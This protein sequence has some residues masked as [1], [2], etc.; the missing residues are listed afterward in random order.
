MAGFM[1]RFLICNVFISGM[2]GILLAA[3]QIFKNILSGRMQYNLWF[4]LLGLLAVPFMPFRFIGFP[5]IFSWLD[6]LGYS[7]AFNAG[8]ATGNIAGTTPTGNTDWINDFTL[9]VNSKT[10]S[11]IGY[12]LLAIW[13]AGILA[14]ILLVIKS[15]F[16]LR[17][18][19]KSALPLQ[20]LEVRRLYHR[21]L[22]E[23]KIT[24]DIPVYS[25]AFLKSPVIVGLLRPCIYL[26]IHL[27][28]DY[29]P[30]SRIICQ[31]TPVNSTKMANH[32]AN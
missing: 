20:N 19:V 1:I 10:P 29:I 11:M 26:P 12:I 2:I 4:L 15:S 8:T 17:A 27:I 31:Q 13:I 16:R 3:K 22:N 28:S 30:V 14:M 32:L 24:R 23:M 6:I 9:S 18:L 7:P 21:C 5:Q 25:T